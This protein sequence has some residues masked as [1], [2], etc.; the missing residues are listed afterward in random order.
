MSAVDECT[1][2]SPAR[3]SSPASVSALR[4]VAADD[5]DPRR[6]ALGQQA[7]RRLAESLRATVDHDDPC[8]RSS[9]RSPILCVAL[10]ASIACLAASHLG[11]VRTPLARRPPRTRRPPSTRTRRSASAITSVR[12]AAR[13]RSNARSSSSIEPTVS[14]MQPIAAAWAAKSTRDEVRVACVV[15]LVVERHAALV[16]LQAVDHREATVVADDDDQ[17]VTG[18]HRAVQV[19]VH[20]QV[21]A[22]AD[23]RRSP[24][25]SGMRHLRPPRPADLVAHA[26]EPVLAVEACRVPSPATR[27]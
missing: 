24:R 26:R 27:C 1:R 9:L 22:V 25:R 8:P 7:H 13:A 20:H 12:S 10:P 2:V 11:A 18:Q 17:L 14:V 16:D 21:R 15:E 19:A 23:E 6:T 4:A 5:G 3:L